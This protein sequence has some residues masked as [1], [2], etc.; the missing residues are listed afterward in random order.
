MTLKGY[1]THLVNAVRGAAYFALI[2]G[3]QI[4]PETIV[5]YID[6][7]WVGWLGIE[8]AATALVHYFRSQAN[9]KTTHRTGS[10]F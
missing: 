3:Y 5:A 7:L 2:A 1:R 8:A 4:D 9:V 6:Q 10:N